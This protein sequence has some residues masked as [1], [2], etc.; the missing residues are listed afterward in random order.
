[1][2]RR[3]E[4]EAPATVAVAR[5]IARVALYL[6]TPC[7]GCIPALPQNLG[8]E[9]NLERSLAQEYERAA[10]F[11]EP[12]LTGYW[13]E[14]D[15][16]GGPGTVGGYLSPRAS[17]ATSPLVIVLPGASSFYDEG[18][19]AKARDYHDNFLAHVHATGARAWTLVVSECGTPYGQGDVADVVQAIDWLEGGGRD[20]LGVNRVFVLGNSSGSTV[21]LLTSLER[22]TDGVI[23]VSA[24]TTLD[25]FDANTW[26]YDLIGDLYPLNAGICQFD[27]TLRAY[28]P[29]GS[30]AW[31]AF[32]ITKRV[33]D[34]RSPVL[35]M[36]GAQDIV[37][38]VRNAE[39][40]ERAYQQTVAQGLPTQ[41]ME[42]VYVADGTHL[43]M[44]EHPTVIR[45]VVAFLE[46]ATATTT[47]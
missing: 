31:N 19:V 23:A 28:G 22:A 15:R 17:D 27:D 7:V 38:G 11:T 36:H 4:P 34:L 14:I 6:L 20:S 42:F 12:D 39:K 32:S 45:Q 18:M 47:D 46:M 37:F 44:F 13:L 40:L 3:S 26:F 41:P 24:L 33:T 2:R 29:P 35:V 25:D 16:A 43:D 5:C 10:L 30:D 8:I 1:V 9:P 21:A